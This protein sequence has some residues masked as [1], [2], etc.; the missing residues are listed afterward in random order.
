MSVTRAT[1]PSPEPAHELDSAFPV[2]SWE[3]ETA[4]FVARWGRSGGVI[5]V[6]GELD[7]A[8]ADEFAEQLR[9]C[10]AGCEWLVVD[11]SDLQFIGTAG[12]S[13]LQRINVGCAQTNVCWAMVPG[14]ATQ[15]LLRVCDPHATLPAAESISEAL[16]LV[17]DPRRLLHLIT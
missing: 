17:Q 9:R 7:A 8:N 11:L 3:S 13:A 16:I 4:R 12:F 2:Q 5:S 6:H 15:R 14:V 1:V 10:A